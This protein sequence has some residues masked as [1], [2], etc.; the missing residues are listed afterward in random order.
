MGLEGTTL[1]GKYRLVRQIGAGGMGRVF[2][3]VHEQT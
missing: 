2:E 1:G 3:A